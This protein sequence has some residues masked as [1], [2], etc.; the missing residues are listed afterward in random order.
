MDREKKESNV[1]RSKRKKYRAERKKGVII[2]SE[3]NPGK[4]I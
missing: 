3:R 4:D 2:A 1:W